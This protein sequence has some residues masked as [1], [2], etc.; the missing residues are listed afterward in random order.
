MCDIS[1]P[2]P[3]RRRYITRAYSRW[4]KRQKA[5]AKELEG[6]VEDISDDEFRSKDETLH[7]C[8]SK[9]AETLKV[10]SVDFHCEFNRKRHHT[11]EYDQQDLIVRRGSSFFLSFT[12]QRSIKPDQDLVVLQLVTGDRPKQSKS[13]INRLTVVAPSGTKDK[14]VQRHLWQAKC[15]ELKGST[16]KIEVT[17]A[18][19]A[20]I[21]VYDT[22][23]ETK[24]VKDPE[25]SI[26]RYQVQ[27]DIIVLFNPWCKDDVVYME[28]EKDKE[29][30]VLN[31]TGRIWVGSAFWNHGRKWNFGQFDEPCLDAALTVLKNGELNEN[32]YKNP[33][34]VI[35]CLSAII[36][37]NDDNGILEGRWT[38]KYPKNCTTPTSWTGSVAI[39]KEYM[40]TKTSV[41]YGQCWVF[42]GVMTTLC[43]ALGIPTRSVTNFESAHD[44]D[45][46]MTIDFHFNKDGDPMSYLD[47]SVW[48]FHVWNESWL[49]RPDLPAGY[50]GWQAH[51]ATPQETSGGI[52]RCGPAPLTAIK[53]GHVYLL[54]DI[55]FIFA[56]VNGDRVYW[57]QNEDNDMGIMD[58]VKNAVGKFISTKAVGSDKRND[59]THLYKYP[60]GSEKEREVVEFVNRFSSRAKED[61]YDQDIVK[62]V[63]FTFVH[64]KKAEVGERFDLKVKMKSYSEATRTIKVKMTLMSAFYTGISKQKVTA[65]EEIVK[66]LPKKE[67]EFQLPVEFKEYEDHL[68]T[69]AAFSAFVNCKVTETEQ[70]FVTVEKFE[71]QMPE[72][73]ITCP[74][75]MKKTDEA[76]M[77]IS[78]T[79][80]LSVNLTNVVLNIEG[81]RIVPPTVIRER[82]LPPNGKLVKSVTLKPSR[83]GNRSIVCNLDSD[84][85]KGVEGV[86]ETE[87]Y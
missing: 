67:V 13:T 73:D 42:S 36:N 57:I 22:F 51:D 48:N 79:N 17:P 49:K 32:G 34:I 52:M 30:Y 39:L 4:L 83:R 16:I 9:H 47:D 41:Q 66:L 53:E 25:D 72:L 35:R 76:E 62:D 24:N 77:V 69:N 18:A 68:C 50:D 11:S 64:P 45:S 29:E 80:P 26:E 60:E 56:E 19:N 46:S 1:T 37:S 38:D 15:V 85:L 87:V 23:L 10:A 70:C 84:Q 74:E 27:G 40:E 82:Y 21:G 61:I 43:R 5:L 2:P 55:P 33:I 86:G 28:D 54:Y 75:K 7:D 63:V 8:V 78:F 31:D 44:S 65:K 12:F 81:A 20:F 58:I 3:K 59:I 14:K 71:L 6:R